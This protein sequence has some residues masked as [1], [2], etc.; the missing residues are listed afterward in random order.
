RGFEKVRDLPRS[1]IVY[2][3]RI[4]PISEEFKGVIV[5]GNST[6]VKSEISGPLAQL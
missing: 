1:G 5:H 3:N 2:L 4:K 6:F